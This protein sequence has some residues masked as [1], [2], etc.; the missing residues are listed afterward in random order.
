[1]LGVRRRA[2][3]IAAAVAILALPGGAH[4]GEPPNPNDP[5][6]SG[7]RN[8]CGTTGTGFYANYRYGL[9]WFGDFRG[10]VPNERHTYCID[11]RYWYPAPRHR[12]REDTSEVLR[13]RDGETV[14]LESKRRIAYAIWEYGRTVNRNQAAAVMLYV[15]ALMGDARPGEV[16]PAALNE[17][18]EAIH[19][20]VARDAARYH[21]PYRV[22]LD[23][24]RGLRVGEQG[25]ATIRVLSAGGSALP[26]LAVE[27]DA[28]GASGIPAVVRTNANGVATVS[29]TATSADDVRVTARA[30]GLAST[31]P[32]I[33]EPTT[34]AAA[35]NGQRLAVADSQTVT[36][37]R[38][39]AVARSRVVVSSV[40]DP[41]E[42]LVGA[43][44]RDRVTIRGV[45]QDFRATV[46]SR[47]YGPFRTA[48]SIRCDLPPASESTWQTDGPGDYRTPPL[49]LDRPGWYVY[50]QTVPGDDNHL[51]AATPC[52]EPRERV[53]V[54]VQPR[55]RTVVSS[56]RTAPGAEIFDRVI[57]EGLAGETATVQA[58][59][60]G[61]FAT[62]EAIACTANPVWSGTVEAAGDGEYLTASVRLTVAGFYTYRETIAQS[63][64]VRTAE[65]RCGEEAETAIVPGAPQVRT[66]VSEQQTRPGA[67][68]TDRLVVTGLGALT[69][70]VKVDLFGPF[71]TR[72]GIS[73]EGTPVWTGTLNA[74]GDGTYTTQPFTIQRVGYYTYRESI[75]ETPQY[76]AFTGRCGEETETTLTRAAPRVTTLVSNEVVAPGFRIHDTVRVQGLGESEARIGVELFGPFAT[77][78]GI[79]CT[80]EPFWTG[81]IFARGDGTLRTPPVELQQAGFY[82]YREHLVGSELVADARTE[83]GEVLQTA[84]ARPLILTGQNERVVQARAAAPGPLAPA[85]VRLRAR[86]I[87]APV[88]PA[89]IDVRAGALAAP[90]NIGRLGWWLDGSD[91]GSETGSVLIAGHVDSARAGPGALV[92]LHEARRGDRIQV[93]ARN[94]RV[95]DYRV[96]SVQTV[97]KPQLPTRIYSRA[98]RHRL[99]LVTCG[100]PF[101]QS[102]GAYRDNVIVTAVRG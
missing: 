92:R 42:L 44:S 11:L 90:A 12:F 35:P 47:L 34:P 9:R 88:F 28:T 1:V 83:C 81:E 39:T 64:L 71:R 48:S 79:R 100:G 62:R 67:G 43:E 102:E 8:T 54:V 59:L 31:L 97:P 37:S 85:R 91:L 89:A 30:R 3:T 84:L 78:E 24:P 4:A 45:A 57:V 58:A 5:C 101:V 99:V 77:R 70:P 75:A 10:V 66:Q 80:G 33:F 29:L 21:G 96:T 95:F 25:S 55:V 15:H 40:A 49:K 6:S 86:G 82:T 68:L 32:H 41:A 60:Y 94:G 87:D 50:V 19:A 76:A 14:S 22:D 2:V 23:M 72:S 36:A 16:D 38:T 61:P 53:K 51:G 73:C 93:T 74:T 27:L 26:E 17:S 13:N 18:V 56:Q 52:T 7:G 69:A 46:T 63:E 98:G 65:T 20:R